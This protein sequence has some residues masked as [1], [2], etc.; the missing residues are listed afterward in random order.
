MPSSWRPI[1]LV[2]LSSSSL[3]VGIAIAT[4]AFAA[5]GPL[6]AVW[7][8]SAV[9]A[10]LMAAYIRPRP[11][12]FTREQIAAIVPYALALVGMNV[13]IFLALDQAPLGVVSAILMLGPL[14]VA[15][16]GHRGIIDLGCVA[17]AALGALTLSLAH[18]VS[19][20]I[21]GTG[22]VF[23]LIGA[24]SF[25]AYI[26]AGKRVSQRVDGLGG[27]ALAL[28]ISAAIQ[29]PIG[30]LFGAPG[31][32]S[33]PVLGALA[34]AGVLATLIPF[35][36]E[37]TALRTLSMA[38]F[39]LLLSLEPAVAAIA[40]YAIRRQELTSLQV[41]GIGLVVAASALSLGPRT[42]TRRLLRYDRDLMANPRVAALARVPLFNGLSVRE[43]ATIADAAEERQAV[44]GQVLTEQ[45][46]DGDEFFVVTDGEV[47]VSQDG[48]HVRTLGPGD[49]LGEIALVFGGV[50][51][52]T[53]TVSRAASLFVIDKASFNA[54]IKRQPR[55]E[56]K[57]LTTV[58]ER[59]RYR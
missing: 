23:A 19:G 18:G 11:R 29:T 21:S 32:W 47:D 52:A 20:P 41:A 22:I 9:G 17:L 39:G 49:F 33:W 54:M 57:I 56:D 30:I 25:G 14:T 55:I 35:A 4:S 37:M 1:L 45:G 53:A 40:G 12:D 24:A 38:T 2:L 48:R 43:L 42:W 6:G 13:F 31:L 34:A 59:M 44:A 16:V 10:V 28:L 26:V 27:L 5:A 36:L 51:T 15:A 50:R 58:S 7:I 8:R 3:Q 46:E